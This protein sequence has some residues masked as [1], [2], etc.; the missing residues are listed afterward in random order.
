MKI[1]ARFFASFQDVFG[2]RGRDVEL[3]EGRSVRDFL[4]AA[5][6]SPQRQSEIFSGTALKPHIVVMVNGVHI[7]SLQGLETGL[8]DGDSVAVFPFLGGG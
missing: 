8:A 5:C 6:D 1:K 4:S 7:Q 2:G 3:P